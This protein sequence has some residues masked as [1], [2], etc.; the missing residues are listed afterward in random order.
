[1]T[2]NEYDKGYKEGYRHGFIKG[3]SDGV[4]DIAERTTKFCLEAIDTIK[5]DGKGKKLLDK[6]A[7]LSEKNN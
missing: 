6:Q 3:F 4:S 2:D 5:F 7:L 1:M